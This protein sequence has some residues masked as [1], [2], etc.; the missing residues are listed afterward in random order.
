MLPE[1]HWKTTGGMG[2]VAY[3]DEQQATISRINKINDSIVFLRNRLVVVERKQMLNVAE[4]SF[5]SER[6]HTH[7]ETVNM[8][9]VALEHSLS[10][11]RNAN[12]ANEAST[13]K[14][15]SNME[16]KLQLLSSKLEIMRSLY[17]NATSAGS[18]SKNREEVPSEEWTSSMATRVA[19]LETLI[20]SAISEKDLQSKELQ[21]RQL[22]NREFQKTEPTTDVDVEEIVRNVWMEVAEPRLLEGLIETA[23]VVVSPP[24]DIETAT[25]TTPTVAI[26]PTIAIIPASEPAP[27]RI[28]YANRRSG[29]LVMHDV[30]S[31]TFVPDRLKFDRVVERV[32]QSWVGAKTAETVARTV[33]AVLPLPSVL[34]LLGA[35]AG[36]GSPE[37]AIS[38]DMS[39]GSCWPMAGRSGLLIV[40]LFQQVSI[41]EVAIGHIARS[42]AIDL[43]SAPRAFSMFASD[44]HGREL[45][46][47][48]EGEYS[49]ESRPSQSF[50][51]ADEATAH[52]P[53]QFV[54][55]QIHSNHGHADYT[56]L[57]SFKVFGHVDK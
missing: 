3:I 50:K 18:C 4:I 6:L 28:D 35:D 34:R 25:T 52:G 39:L 9:K 17:A 29:G 23:A 24:L 2:A 22:Q 11:L 38:T 5:I 15:I 27:P 7:N 48:A 45:R 20:S 40:K 44:E 57:Y 36:V 41:T 42:E 56:C 55:L 13:E 1:V 21:N 19:N 33:A 14:E 30:S 53:V 43:R 32:M 12:A 51:V 49:L 46:L 16:I 8:Q 54:A 31:D 26:T 10:T 37:D 47:L